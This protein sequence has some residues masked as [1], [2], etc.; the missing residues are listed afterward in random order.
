MTFADKSRYDRTFQQVTHKGGESAINYIKRF[1]NAHALSVLVGNSY[2]EDQLIHTFLYNFHQGGKYSAQIASH[3]AEL[4]REEK[5]TDKKSSNI[6]S[7][8]TYYLNLDSRSGFGRNSEISHAVQTKCTFCGG[9]NESAEKCFK[10]IRKEKEKARA[11]DFSSNRK[12]ERTPQKCFRCGPE[13]HTIAKIPKPPKDNE[14]RRKQVR[15]NEKGNHA[16]DNG[17]NNSDQKIYASM[18][19]MSGNDECSS[20][21]FGDSSQLTNCILDSGATCHMTPEVSDVIP[22][23]L[24]D[25]DKYIEVAD[26]NHVR[27]KQKGQL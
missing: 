12:M 23:S 20:K 5:F 6:S 17:K 19:H 10:R 16:C 15:F 2:S 24:E 9:E 14:K 22:G 8:Q 18:A 11:V 7:L 25:T 21:F 13:D 26:V 27:A 3:Q 1:Q 4:R